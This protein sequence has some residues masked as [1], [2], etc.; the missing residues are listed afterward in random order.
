LNT[1]PQQFNSSY[2]GPREKLEHLNTCSREIEN[3]HGGGCTR[4]GVVNGGG[5]IWKIV[6]TAKTV[7]KGLLLWPLLKVAAELAEE[8]SSSYLWLTKIHP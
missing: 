8:C 3:L 4:R 2:Y 7:D 6:P 5:V 1:W